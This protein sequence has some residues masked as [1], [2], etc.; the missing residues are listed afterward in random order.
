MPEIVDVDL[1]RTALGGS[2]SFHD[3]EIQALRLDSAQRSD[4]EA[5]LELEIHLFVPERAD[6]GLTFRNHTLAT[7]EFRGV[8]DVDLSG[9][10][11]QN[12]LFDLVLVDAPADDRAPI[13]VELQASWGLSGSLRCRQVAVTAATPFTPGPHSVYGP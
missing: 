3:A 13:T 4:G 2:P 11:P 12:V 7:L 10:Q 5:R 1:L 8:E 6:G 9:F